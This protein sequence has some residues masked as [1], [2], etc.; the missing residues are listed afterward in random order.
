MKQLLAFAPRTGLA[1]G[2]FGLAVGIV[3]GFALAG[4]AP[5]AQEIKPAPP[6]S[7]MAPP[8]A[9]VEWVDVVGPFRK[10]GGA[11]G[12]NSR[13]EK[14]AEKGYVFADLEPYLENGDLQGYWVVYMPAE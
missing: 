12:I 7:A 9:V 1:L 8:I 5:Q 14:M 4:Q 11:N 13:N 10:N 3:I 6:Q 2:L